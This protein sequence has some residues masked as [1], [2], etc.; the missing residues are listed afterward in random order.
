M[1]VASCS[2]RTSRSRFFVHDLAMAVSTFKKGVPFLL[3]VDGLSA[4]LVEVNRSPNLA[5][6][7]LKQLRK[8][9]PDATIIALGF[10]DTRENALEF[11]EAGASGYV[12]LCATVQDVLSVV[13]QARNDEFVSTPRVTY[14]LC[15]WLAELADAQDASRSLAVR[16]TIREREVWELMCAGH[17]NR[18]IAKRLCISQATVKNHVHRVLRKLDIKDRY[19][20]SHLSPLSLHVTVRSRGF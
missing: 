20:A 5:I 3:V 8:R 4:D 10:S 12:P 15:S 14:A 13:R 19:I 2:D 9:H 17:L 7:L 11:Y 1:V 18:H 16:L 6:R